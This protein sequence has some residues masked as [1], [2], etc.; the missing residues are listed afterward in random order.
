MPCLRL[1][2]T[3]VFSGNEIDRRNAMIECEHGRKILW[4]GVNKVFLKLILQQFIPTLPAKVTGYQ[5]CGTEINREFRVLEYPG[6][7]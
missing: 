2:R 4:N 1:Q 7:D 5:S 3:V 6:L